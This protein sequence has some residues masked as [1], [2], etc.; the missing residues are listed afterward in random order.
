MLFCNFCDCAMCKYGS[1][2]NVH[3]QTVQGTW[4]CDTCFRYDV[5]TS[6]LKPGYSKNGPCE[7]INCRHRPRLRTGEWLEFEPKT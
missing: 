4:I 3:A 1:E 2:G 7:D 6:P 5:C